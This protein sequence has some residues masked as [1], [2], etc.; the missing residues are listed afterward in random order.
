MSVNARPHFRVPGRRQHAAI[1]RRRSPFV[2]LRVCAAHLTS[3]CRLI[4]FSSP[5]SEPGPSRHRCHPVPTR[6]NAQSRP[7]AGE[8]IDDQQLTLGRAA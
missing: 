5:T 2:I 4:C 3:P 1:H 7:R 8:R 6:C